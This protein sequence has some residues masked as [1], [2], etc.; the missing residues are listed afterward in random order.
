MR[1]PLPRT[2]IISLLVLLYACNAQQTPTQP[3]RIRPAPGSPYSLNFGYG[4]RVEAGGEDSASALRLAAQMNM[5]WVALDFHWAAIQPTP[6]QWEDA[7]F[8]SAVLLARELGL[9]TL[10]A[11]TNPPAWAMT[12]QGPNAD[13]AAAL[14]VSLLQRYPELGAL[15]LFPG[16]NTRAGW[17]AAPQ[18]KDYVAL[19]EKIRARLETENL[20]TSLIMSSLNNTLS[21]PTDV[22]DVDFLAQVYAAGL[23]PA[24]VGIR[25][26][27]L[28]GQP[29][30]PPSATSLRHFEDLRAVMIA[31]HHADGLLWI[32]GFSLSAGS[33]DDTWLKQAYPMTQSWLYLG[34]AFYADNLIDA[35]GTLQPAAHTLIEVI[36]TQ[37]G[38]NARLMPEVRTAHSIK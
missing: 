25:L 6:N 32:T 28:T 2:L 12:P 38:I 22:R 5:D 3:K 34:A 18:A 30:Q 15:E 29:L 27:N 37:K 11:V 35:N 16:A 19:F 14:A 36:N 13:A 20:N 8:S 23:R 33:P 31:N 26:D 24:I 9:A 17:G 10:V 7:S 21:F 4:M 1:N